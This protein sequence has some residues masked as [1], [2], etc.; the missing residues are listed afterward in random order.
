M[1][2]QSAYSNTTEAV[3]VFHSAASLQAAVDDLLTQG[4]NRMDL[5]VLASE[6]A[7][8]AKL[9]EIYVPA[10]DL[11]DRVEVPTT[12]FISVESVG[13]AMGAVIGALVYVP[14]LIGGA[15]I[16]ASGGT[17]AAA[18]AAAAISGGIGGSV[19]TVLGGLIGKNHYDKIEEHLV[20]GGLLLWIRTRDQKHEE[21]ALAI[22]KGHD[23]DGVHLHTIPTLLEA[24]CSIP[25]ED[26]VETA[27]AKTSRT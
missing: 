4:F 12:A 6:K 13:A 10:R 3:G 21:R 19:G 22:L 24:G 8:E 7:I 5:S 1:T 26:V 16:V 27:S 17:M 9:H 2:E 18:M 15:V 23:A 11:E 25:L 20:S 14:A